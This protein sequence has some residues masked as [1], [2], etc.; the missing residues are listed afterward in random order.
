MNIHYHV[1][2][3]IEYAKE[4]LRMREDDVLFAKN[5]VMNLLDLHTDTM[6]G[7]ETPDLDRVK[8]ADIPDSFVRP[9]SDYAIEKGL[10][11]DV[12]RGLFETAILGAVTPIPSQV[13][14]YFKKD[15]KEVGQRQALLNLYD[16]GIKS[17]Y[18]KLSDV[19]RNVYWRYKGKKCDLEIT[20]NLSKPEKDNK[21]I[22]R[23]KNAP[24]T[25][26]PKC[27]LCEENVGYKGRV[28]FPARQTLRFVPIKLNNEEWNMQYSPYMYYDE[29][30]IIFSKKHTPMILERA[31]FVKLLEFTKIFPDYIAGSNACLP[32]VGGS[33]LTHE[34]YQGGGHLMPVHFTQPRWEFK[35]KDF[36][37]LT[38]YVQEWYNSDVRVV[39]Q[40]IQRVADGAEFIRKIWIDYTD[41]KVGIISK[42][43]D[44]HNAIT[45]IARRIGSNYSMDLL[46]RNNRVSEEYPDGI[47]HA[48]PEYHNVKKEGIGLIEAMGLFILPGRLDKEFGAISEI[49]QG[50]EI[51]YKNPESMLKKHERMIE[52][53][54]KKHGT[55][56][57]KEESV[58]VIRDYV[59]QVCENILDN[60]AVFKDDTSGRDAFLRFMSQAGF[61]KVG[62]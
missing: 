32:I 1:N 40:D 59:G 43:T 48:H 2:S 34:H 14:D 47:F 21:E 29:H 7:E 25:G 28:G 9:L 3:L 27:M 57:S 33:I 19:R 60:T 22:A 55:S 11:E 15:L 51:D 23:L 20:I 61:E 10:I 53:L 8:S 56:M 6:G 13:N 36:P 50:R 42:T 30:C 16:L 4:H 17:N 18:I 26:Y 46:L 35:H 37:D 24:A 49:L 39:G 12:D 31:T 52:E 41:E 62:E 44:A 38:F 5:A 45:P 54:V 58:D